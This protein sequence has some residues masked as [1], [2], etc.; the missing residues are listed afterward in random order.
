MG[1]YGIYGNQGLYG[2]YDD[3]GLKGSSGNQGMAAMANK[4]SMT[5]T[6]SSEATNTSL[7]RRGKNKLSQ[8][9]EI[10]VAKIVVSRQKPQVK[11]KPVKFGISYV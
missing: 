5:T 7:A 11:T 6:T 3:Q 1:I 2:S 8:M 4:T 10:Q 9:T